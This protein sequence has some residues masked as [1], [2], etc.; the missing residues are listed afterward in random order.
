MATVQV[1]PANDSEEEI[2]STRTSPAVGAVAL[3][4]FAGFLATAVH[5][6]SNGAG[7]T[8]PGNREDAL[9]A[10]T[11]VPHEPEVKSNGE[12]ERENHRI[13][14][15]AG[16]VFAGSLEAIPPGFRVVGYHGIPTGEEAPD[17][18]VNNVPMEL[19]T[20]TSAGHYSW[21]SEVFTAGEGD[22]VKSG[23]EPTN[24]YPS[25]CRIHD[26]HDGQDDIVETKDGT[27]RIGCSY[28]V[29]PIAVG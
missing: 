20:I 4:L 12:N 19:S 10:P 16:F 1:G 28:T 14:L 3:M 21:Y 15:E 7:T 6:G 27:G 23:I 25:F 17:I 11:A 18:K 22:V 13:F 5:S 24:N 26:L 9:S 29:K 2:V 8:P